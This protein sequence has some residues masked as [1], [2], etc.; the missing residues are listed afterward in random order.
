MTFSHED[1]NRMESEAIENYRQKVKII[2]RRV[3]T[4]YGESFIFQVRPH[5]NKPAT[6][7]E[8]LVVYE[9]VIERINERV[10]KLKNKM[11]KNNE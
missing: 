8:A 3:V 1:R 5:W 9:K 2:D 4:P 11:G 7:K 10:E 6:D